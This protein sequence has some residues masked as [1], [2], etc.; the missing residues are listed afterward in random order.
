MGDTFTYD[1]FEFFNKRINIVP[2][3]E[4]KKF[5]KEKNNF[6]INDKLKEK[7]M[8]LFFDKNKIEVIKYKQNIDMTQ[9]K[10]NRIVYHEMNRGLFFNF[11]PILTSGDLSVLQGHYGNNDNI[12]ID[13]PNELKDM[14]CDK[15][16]SYDRDKP[17]SLDKKLFDKYIELFG[18]EVY[19]DFSLAE[20]DA[21]NNCEYHIIVGVYEHRKDNMNYRLVFYKDM[22]EEEDYIMRM[23]SEEHVDY[24]KLDIGRIVFYFGRY[25]CDDLIFMDLNCIETNIDGKI[26]INNKLCRYIYNRKSKL[27][28]DN[29]MTSEIYNFYKSR[30]N[31]LTNLKSSGNVIEDKIVIKYLELLRNSKEIKINNFLI[32]KNYIKLVDENFTIEFDD[33]FL[34]IERNFN[35]LYKLLKNKETK[36]NFNI[37]YEKIIEISKMGEVYPHSGTN[38]KSSSV[39]VNGLPV[40]LEKNGN[41]YYINNIFIMFLY[42]YA[43]Q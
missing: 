39:I 17:N 43:K 26:I 27:I 29:L 12:F 40:T 22:F 16:N 33:K 34:N 1:E 38:F 28:S 3:E 6:Y 9:E 11:K 36:Y 7:K 5:K 37:L 20:S 4:F 25:H 18:L 19:K 15:L 31:S 21:Y 10:L 30:I 32:H 41:R 24:T 42:V 35:D 23:Y 2:K 14:I 13:T 8:F